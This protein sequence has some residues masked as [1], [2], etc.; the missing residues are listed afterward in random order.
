M[1]LEL[2]EKLE[3]YLADNDE[4]M[5]EVEPRVVG[6]FVNILSDKMLSMYAYY[7]VDKNKFVF[8]HGK[9]IEI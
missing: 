5:F 9:D 8:S 6:E 2:K 7:Q 3:R 1:V 4:F